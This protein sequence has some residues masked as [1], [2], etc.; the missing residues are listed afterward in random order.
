MNQ[1]TWQPILLLLGACTV[2]WCGST[3]GRPLDGA[4]ELR[5]SAVAHELTHRDNWFYLTVNDQ[6]YDEKPPL[7]FWMMAGVIQI[8]GDDHS[9]WVYRFPGFIAGT[10][11]VLLTYAIGRRLVNEHVGLLA[12][13][14]LICSHQIFKQATIARLDMVYTAFIVAA[15]W[16]WIEA[17]AQG[18]MRPA[19][20]GVF[21]LMV[22]AAFFS[23]GPLAPLVLFALMLIECRRARSWQDWRMTR[24]ALGLT[25]LLSAIGG[26]MWIQHRVYGGHFVENQIY[27]QSVARIG[28][29]A[30]HVKPMWFYLQSIVG[31]GFGP[32]GLL[33]LIAAAVGIVRWRRG[34]RLMTMSP[35]VGWTLLFFVVLSLVPAKRP[36]YLLPAYPAMAIIAAWLVMT[37]QAAKPLTPTWQRWV[38]G[39]FLCSGAAL[40]ALPLIMPWL[41]ASMSLSRVVP[42]ELAAVIVIALAGMVRRACSTRQVIYAVMFYLMALQAAWLYAIDPMVPQW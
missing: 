38:G 41:C 16:L 14:I 15:L 13:M 17:R 37:Y 19:V 42:V 25:M 22:A 27:E 3:N 5:Y 24:P 35:L 28:G 8:I 6:P 9:P 32:W 2:L 20:C 1:A 7:V 10:V 18:R 40:M 39:I 31:E 30:P 12:A 21:W 23:K 11:T 26:W 34:E 33:V 36:E 4:D 29:K